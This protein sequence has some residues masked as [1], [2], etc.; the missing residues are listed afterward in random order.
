MPP[1]AENL[2]AHANILGV[3]FFRIQFKVIDQIRKLPEWL[4][5]VGVLHELI[6]SG[7]KARDRRSRAFRPEKINEC[8]MPT[9][10]RHEGGFFIYH[11]PKK[12]ERNK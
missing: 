1:P 3:D 6:F 5:R 11:I 12:I 9:R 2:H 4:N 8:D 7:R 10:I